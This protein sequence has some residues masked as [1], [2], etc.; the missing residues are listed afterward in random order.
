MIILNISQ[1][2][3]FPKTAASVINVLDTT[4]NIS[5]KKYCEYAINS[6]YG[7]TYSNRQ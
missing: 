2:V 3:E 1:N 5:I 4:E 6:N 7:A